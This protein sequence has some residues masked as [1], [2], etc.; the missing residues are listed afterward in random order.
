M[1]NTDIF[2]FEFVDRAD[3]RKKV[4]EYLADFSKSPGYVLWLNGKRGTGKSFFLTEHVTTKREFTSI[5]VNVEIGNATPEAYLKACVAQI[6]KA[7][8]LKFISYLRANYS[9]IIEIGQ[10][11]VNIA[12]NAVKLDDMGIDELG[13]SITSYF[14]S[15]HGE[16]EN[17]VT[18]I[19]KYI[20]EAQKQCKNLVFLLDNFSQCDTAS[21]G[22]II[23][24]IHEMLGNAHIRFILCTTDEDLG[25]RLDIRQ[26]IAE[27][28]PNQPLIL[29]PFQQK[30]LFARMLEHS[31]DLDETNIKLLIQAFELC[32]G[33]P[34]Q[35]KIIL[36]NLY[37]K[38]GIEVGKEKARFIP[39]IFRKMLLKGEMSFDIDALCKE[40]KNAKVILQTIAF[41][42]API[43]TNVL[44]DFLDL[45]IEN[46]IPILREETKRT[47][48]DLVQR[49]ILC[50][51]FD[52]GLP[53]YQFE[54]DSLTLAVREYFRDDP[55]VAFLH[56]NIYGYLMRHENDHEQ[57]YWRNH[58]QSLRAYHSYASQAD[59]WINY[60]FLYGKNFFDEMRYEEAQSI[61]SRLNSFM[62]S[63]SGEQ[64]LV[65]AIT[66]YHC[67]Q[68][69]QTDELLSI[70]QRKRLMGNF[71]SNQLMQLYIF[72]ARSKSCLLDCANALR[73]IQQ[74]EDLNIK[75]PRLYVALMGTKQSILYLAPGHFKEAKVLFDSLVEKDLNIR[76]MALVYQSAMDYYDGD[77][78]LSYLKKG[79]LLSDEFSDLIIKGKILNNM[80]FEHL[81]CGNYQQARQYFDDSVAILKEHQPHELGF[82]YSN[83]A[84]LHMILGEWE[85][86]LDN[87]VEALFWNKSEYASLVLKT[88]RMLCYFFLNNSQWEKL[89]DELYDYITSEHCVD[90]KI[91]KKICINM[92]LLSYKSKRLDQACKLL[93]YCRPHMEGEMPHGCYR[94]LNLEQ[95][96][97]GKK[98]R[99]P[100]LHESRFF[101]YYCEIE[102][103][104]WLVNFSHD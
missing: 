86:A 87:I 78:A 49:H 34:Q 92:A 32:Q 39:E 68:Y 2:K 15:K 14:V 52:D 25:K 8:D 95:K 50:Y 64:L 36:I 101:S 61:F 77:I 60:N 72:Q 7:A 5:Y 98:L 28:I 29:H 18:V 51:I 104:P 59:G 103:D 44:Y 99:L 6:N 83:I 89:F 11:V 21:L 75:D 9:S 23:P 1:L 94:F 85:Q 88:N 81:R 80:G 38:Q 27:K 84:V 37:T 102:F 74:A 54:H 35:F 20:A 66:L 73:V 100:E 62:A 91:Y 24:V 42:G 4:D 82:P 26:A 43:P 40:H 47:L 96:I 97:T 53:Q 48:Q 57:P 76:E 55:S 79:L 56:Y 71:S 12:L 46:G 93:E 17:T 3:E 19:K 65:M 67:G 16:K 90:N 45:Y 69:Q 41:W 10:K 58:Y 31:F 30:H 22:I 70:I 63:L 33:L 13:A